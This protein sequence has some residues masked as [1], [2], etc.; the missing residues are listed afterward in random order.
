MKKILSVML[1]LAFSICAFSQKNA[2]NKDYLKKSKNQKTAFYV[3]AG[4]G[5][6]LIITGLAWDAKI[7]PNKQD[8]TGGLLIALGTVSCIVSIPLLIASNKNKKRSMTFSLKNE[9]MQLL[10]NNF[11]TKKPF[12]ALSLSFHL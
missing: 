4:T 11:I 7:D 10:N 5:V 2:S 1:L 12:S 9:N 6:S 3:L 8:F